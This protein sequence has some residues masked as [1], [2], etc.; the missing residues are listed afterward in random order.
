MA[1]YIRSWL[2]PAVPVP[3]INTQ[4]PDAEDDNITIT[5]DDEEDD[6][7]PAFPALNSAQRASGRA[8][9]AQLMPPP[10]MLALPLSTTK[11]P[12]K[13]SKKREKVALAP[14]HGALDWANLKN[15]GQ[16]LRV[17][18]RR[19]PCAAELMFHRE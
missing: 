10:S 14:G 19:H 13:P 6:S 16:D 2:K 4:E 11:V 7:P 9:D 18:G 5:G 3:Q 8:T 12:A 17:C 1:D 15:S